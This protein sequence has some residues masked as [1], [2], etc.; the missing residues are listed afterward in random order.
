M[1]RDNFGGKQELDRERTCRT[2]KADKYIPVL[3]F[4]PKSLNYKWQHR[5]HFKKQVFQIGAEI[6]YAQTLENNSKIIFWQA[7]S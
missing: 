3:F 6:S 5:F 7:F 2:L 4:S 1:K